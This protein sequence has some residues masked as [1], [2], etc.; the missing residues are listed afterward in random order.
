MYLV[1]RFNLLFQFG[2]KIENAYIFQKVSPR[3]F[4]K[5]VN[6]K[7]QLMNIVEFYNMCYYFPTTLPNF[8]HCL[9]LHQFY[10]RYINYAGPLDYLTYLDRLYN[11]ANYNDDNTASSLTLSTK[12]KAS[13][14]YRDYLA[15]LLQYLVSFMNRTQPLMDLDRVLS[16]V[17]AAFE[18]RCRGCYS[19][20]KGKHLK[21]ALLMELKPN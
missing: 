12:F 11:L 6:P 19:S 17:E 1:Y 16:E 7:F 21:A 10:H 4:P 14:Q 15:D 9:D 3:N 13:M 5:F 20:K 18:G 8:R 2:E